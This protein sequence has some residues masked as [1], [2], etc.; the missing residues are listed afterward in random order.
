MAA[1]MHTDAIGN[2]GVMRLDRQVIDRLVRDA[3]DACDRTQVPHAINQRIVR[4]H[5]A[6]LNE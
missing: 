1:V 4:G 2:E 5:G 6:D 3:L